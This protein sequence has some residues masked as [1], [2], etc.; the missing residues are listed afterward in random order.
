MMCIHCKLEHTVTSLTVCTVFIVRLEYGTKPY[1]KYLH[2]LMLNYIV[3]YTAWIL[4]PHI[5]LLVL[6]RIRINKTVVTVVVKSYFCCTRLRRFL[7]PVA[8]SVNL[9][10]CIYLN[11]VTTKIPDQLFSYILLQSGPNCL[12]KNIM[13]LNK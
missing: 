4:E 11:N 8:S 1:P 3:L 5:T 10:G 6:S 12:E 13:D 7:A 9:A 2:H